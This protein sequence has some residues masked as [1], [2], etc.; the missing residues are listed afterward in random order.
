MPVT[1]VD[2]EASCWVV[3]LGSLIS[4]RIVFPF[5]SLDLYLLAVCLFIC[6]HDELHFFLIC[7][8]I[9]T[10]EGTTSTLD[11]AEN[12]L[13]THQSC[14][15]YV[16]LNA[17]L[18]NQKLRRNDPTKPYIIW[19]YMSILCKWGKFMFLL[20]SLDLFSK[21]KRFNSKPNQRNEI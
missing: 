21:T 3:Q 17:D 7:L 14:N 2:C 15:I 10:V 16:A 8:M 9:S 18:I 4:D 19:L 20:V 12:G 5:F 11:V 6:L 13:L 1:L